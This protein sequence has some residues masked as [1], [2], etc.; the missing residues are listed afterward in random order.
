MA[1]GGG[2]GAGPSGGDAPGQE[3]QRVDVA[4][5]RAVAAH[6]EMQARRGPASGATVPMTAPR[7]AKPRAAIVASGMCVTRHG[8]QRSVTIP[9]APIRPANATGPVHA[10]RTGVP[11]AAARSTPRWRPPSNGR[12]GSN[13]RVGSPG[14]GANSA[15]RTMS[16]LARLRPRPLGAAG[17]HTSGTKPERS[18]LQEVLHRTESV[19]AT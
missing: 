12:P 2:R 5:P 11:G 14:T 9:S 19:D 17:R 10:A 4:E 3:P 1:R 8:P 7:L 15:S 6:A 18:R 16:M 13:P